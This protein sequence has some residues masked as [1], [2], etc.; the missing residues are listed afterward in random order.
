MVSRAL[1]LSDSGWRRKL[2]WEGTLTP[3][4]KLRL[5]CLRTFASIFVPKISSPRQVSISSLHMQ[6]CYEWRLFFFKKPRKTCRQFRHHRTPPPRELRPPY[7]N[8]ASPLNLSRMYFTCGS[9]FDWS[10]ADPSFWCEGP[11]HQNIGLRYELQRVAIHSSFDNDRKTEM[12][13]NTTLGFGSK[14]IGKFSNIQAATT[15]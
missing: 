11:K 6:Y 9:G 12:D 14:K 2:K 15:P 5:R 1:Q 8:D 7:R 13:K 10:E 4:L 3:T